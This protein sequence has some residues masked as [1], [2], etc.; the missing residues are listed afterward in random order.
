MLIFFNYQ[1]NIYPP[2]TNPCP[3]FW[4]IQM[5][6]SCKISKSNAGSMS[7][8][9]NS[10]FLSNKNVNDDIEDNLIV[11]NNA[12]HASDA[13]DA[14]EYNLKVYDV[15]GYDLTN[16]PFGYDYKNGTVD[17]TDV[18]WSTY[19]GSRSKYCSLKAWAN[20]NG[21]IWD[22]VHNYNGCD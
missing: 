8:K 2:N 3:D 9:Q 15:S 4:E 14:S 10:Y 16:I 21:V 20:K 5:D 22:G 12:Y 6:G 11:Y 18:R 19:N 1:S 13:S 7:L 17:F